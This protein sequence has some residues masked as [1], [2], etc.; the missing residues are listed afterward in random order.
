[1][2]KILIAGGTGFLG[3]HLARLAI[4]KK[5]EV[6]CISKTLPSEKR[7]IKNVIY[8]NFDLRKKKKFI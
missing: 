3:F 1:M 4:K 6:Y 5:Y 7:F 8:L 2:K